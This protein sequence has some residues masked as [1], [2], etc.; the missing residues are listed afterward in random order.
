M[1]LTL[2]NVPRKPQILNILYF[3]YKDGKIL[4]FET[5][6]RYSNAESSLETRIGNIFYG[7]EGYLEI[8]GDTWKAF[9]K[10]ENVPFA[11]SKEADG[12][13]S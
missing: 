7:T 8:N 10:R 1:E 3:K 12:A 5:R 13:R 6:G 2:R 4:E 9:R 11:G